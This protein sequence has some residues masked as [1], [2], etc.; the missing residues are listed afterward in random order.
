MNLV[1]IYEAN[2]EIYELHYLFS[3]QSISI[4]KIYLPVKKLNVNNFMTVLAQKQ[5]SN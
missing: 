2:S 3:V 1:D 4:I 5:L